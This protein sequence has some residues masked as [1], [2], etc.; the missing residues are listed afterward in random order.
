MVKEKHFLRVF[1][2]QEIGILPQ[3]PQAKL[4]HP[5]NYAGDD[6]YVISADKLNLRGRGSPNLECARPNLTCR[7]C[8]FMKSTPAKM[9]L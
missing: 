5:D 3:N 9:S 6:I 8:L 4:E 7:M 2:N 1:P